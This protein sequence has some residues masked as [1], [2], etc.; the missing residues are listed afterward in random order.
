MI[1]GDSTLADDPLALAPQRLVA[2]AHGGPASERSGRPAPGE[3]LGED[4]IPYI[5][6]GWL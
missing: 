2:R 5:A 4:P 1:G 6:G 3:H